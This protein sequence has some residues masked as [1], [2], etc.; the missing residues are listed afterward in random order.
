MHVSVLKMVIISYLMKD[1]EQ[2]CC[3]KAVVLTV[4]WCQ[5][6]WEVP[7]SR[8]SSQ[9]KLYNLSNSK[10]GYESFE[11]IWPVIGYWFIG[12][13]LIPCALNKV[14]CVQKKR[15][16][17]RL[18]SLVPS[19]VSFFK[20]SPSSFSVA[21]SLC[22]LSSVLNSRDPHINRICIRTLGM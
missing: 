16:S 12:H 18:S 21:L 1:E 3:V 5:G 17:W 4:S 13:T 2:M 7:W 6:F 9:H 8:I 19:Y 11:I 15:S 14:Q 20:V 22:Q 10:T